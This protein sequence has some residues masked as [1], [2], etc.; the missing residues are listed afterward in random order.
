M[1]LTHHKL[2]T[3]IVSALTIVV[4]LPSLFMKVAFAGDWDVEIPTIVPGTDEQLPYL[5]EDRPDDRAQNFLYA[6][7]N[8]WLD[9]AKN[10]F[11]VQSKNY[12]TRLLKYAQFSHEKL[13]LV[14]AVSCYKEALEIFTNLGCAD[15]ERSQECA[16]GLVL[17]YFQQ[18]EFEKAEKV[19]RNI[20]NLIQKCNCK[21]TNFSKEALVDLSMS[22]YYQSKFKEAAN[23]YT[24]IVSLQDVQ[25]ETKNSD[26]LVL[27]I[28]LYAAGDHEQAEE[29]Y[30]SCKKRPSEILSSYAKKQFQLWDKQVNSVDCSDSRVTVHYASG[31][32]ATR[33]IILTDPDYQTALRSA[34]WIGCCQYKGKKNGEF[35]FYVNSVIKGKL[36]FP[37]Q[38]LHLKL[39]PDQIKTEIKRNIGENREPRTGTNWL[40]FLSKSQKPPGYKLYRNSYGIV[41]G[42]SAT[43]EYSRRWAESRRG[44]P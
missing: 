18:H 41:E 35:G 14:T 17:I 3:Q 25:S 38:I 22:L 34:D 1:R 28:L 19:A 27:A 9:Q 40:V 5:K 26:E 24:K 13:Y 39:E 32:A 16:H 20:C 4:I 10:K 37:N 11:G 7:I 12:A 23:T 8:W 43:V 33:T 42:T 2:K 31:N 6:N 29:L 30:K 21:E 15:I 44:Q 36:F